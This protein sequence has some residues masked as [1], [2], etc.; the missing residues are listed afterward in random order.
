M[1]DVPAIPH[2][3][4]NWESRIGPLPPIARAQGVVYAGSHDGAP[5]IAMPPA[6]FLQGRPEL[7]H[8]GAIG[9]LLEIAAVMTLRAYLRDGDHHMR[10]K[11][12]NITIDYLRGGN[13]VMTYGAAR[14]TRI[15]RTLANVEARIWQADADKPIA[16]A[17]LHYLVRPP[18]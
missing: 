15:G 6:E 16:L 3:P 10:L 1:D 17:H 12:V 18:K 8:G 13:M 11:P 14:I 2:D 4:D 9:S 7:L 5:R